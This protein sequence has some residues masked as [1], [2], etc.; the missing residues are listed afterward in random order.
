M[1]SA[2]TYKPGQKAEVKLKLTDF[3]G[4]PFVGSTVVA[5]YDKSVEYISGGSNVPEIKDFSGSGGGTII[6]NT[7]STSDRFGQPCRCGGKRHDANLGVFG[8]SVVDELAAEQCRKATQPAASAAETGAWWPARR[9]DANR[10]AG[11]ARADGLMDKAMPPANKT[12][13]PAAAW[14]SPNNRRTSR[15]WR[16]A[17]RRRSGSSPPSARICRHGPLGRLA[18]HRRQWH[19][20]SFARH[21]RKPHHLENPVWGMG[22]GTKVGQGESRSHHLQGPDRP[23]ASAAILRREGRSRAVG[24]RAQLPGKKKA[25]EGRARSRRQAAQA[26]D[27]RRVVRTCN[28]GRGRRTA[29]SIGA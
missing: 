1:P 16:H 25:G 4:K 3:G 11:C 5:I 8:D 27:R 17:P 21:A 23:P 28:G 24:Q 14:Q 19:G 2:E 26:D 29:Q 13:S 20:R 18:H 7:E 9:A 12:P 22:H 6:R 15:R 10:P